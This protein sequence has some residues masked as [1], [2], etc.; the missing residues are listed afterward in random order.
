MRCIYLLFSMF[1]YLVYYCFG[2]I[3]LF[4][5]FVVC[6][7]QKGEKKNK[8]GVLLKMEVSDGIRKSN[9]LGFQW[10]LFF[11]ESPCGFRS[12]EG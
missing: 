6:P 9:S 2:F 11:N 1:S 8:E 3:N 5:S 4:F 7:M 12:R 10:R